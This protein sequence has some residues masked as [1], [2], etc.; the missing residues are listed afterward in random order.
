MSVGGRWRPI[1]SRPP[2]AAIAQSGP[3]SAAPPIAGNHFRSALRRCASLSRDR[4][5][6]GRTGARA[7]QWTALRGSRQAVAGTARTIGRRR[8][9]SPANI[10]HSSDL[11]RKHSSVVSRSFPPSFHSLSTG[12]RGGAGIS[13]NQVRRPTVRTERKWTHGPT[14]FAACAGNPCTNPHGISRPLAFPARSQNTAAG[15][16]KKLCLCP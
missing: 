12:G 15:L 10:H 7:E 8:L 16:H 3:R 11:S 5:G 14:E 1:L 6:A 13:G 2:C 4:R 9:I